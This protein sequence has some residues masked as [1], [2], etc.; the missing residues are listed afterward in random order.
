MEPGAANQKCYKWDKWRAGFH[1]EESSEKITNPSKI[2]CLYEFGAL[3]ACLLDL[4]ILPVLHENRDQIDDHVVP[5]FCAS[6]PRH[7]APPHL[8]VL[9]KK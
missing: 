6:F 5:L 3:F 8:E 9:A 4:P 2:S 7:L 1:R